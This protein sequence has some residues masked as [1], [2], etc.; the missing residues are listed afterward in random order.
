MTSFT[1]DEIDAENERKLVG[2]RSANEAKTE[3]SKEV[4]E[5]IRRRF[6][7]DILFPRIIV[8]GVR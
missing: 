4:L 5:K 8:R 1:Y 3:E 2:I 6:F 7:N